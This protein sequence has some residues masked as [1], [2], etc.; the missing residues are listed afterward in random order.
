[1]SNQTVVP[2]SEKNCNILLKDGSKVYNDQ[3]FGLNLDKFD[4]ESQL[5]EIG[6]YDVYRQY[7]KKRIYK[8]NVIDIVEVN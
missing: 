2:Y 4:I 6:Y 3:K 8:D 7:G 1:M 5:N